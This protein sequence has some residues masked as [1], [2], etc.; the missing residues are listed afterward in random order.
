MA[1]DHWSVPAE[2]FRIGDLR[3]FRGTLGDLNIPCRLV[4]LSHVFHAN[5]HDLERW[6]YEDLVTGKTSD[7][8]PAY[9]YSPHTLTEMEALAWLASDQ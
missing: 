1:L 9:L 4:S 2:R 5:G 3:L 8:F 7:P 6:S